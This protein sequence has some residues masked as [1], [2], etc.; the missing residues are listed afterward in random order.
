MVRVLGNAKGVLPRDAFAES[1]MIEVL[2]KFTVNVR[3]H[4]GFFFFKE[5]YKYTVNT[6]EYAQ[7]LIGNKVCT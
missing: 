1:G 6:K 4:C 7:H 3:G 5:N 2:P